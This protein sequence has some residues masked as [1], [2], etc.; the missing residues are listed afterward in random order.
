MDC[1]RKCSVAKDVREKEKRKTLAVS[2]KGL[3]A[4]RNLLVV[5]RHS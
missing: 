4:K 5:N 2:V 3:G 1:D